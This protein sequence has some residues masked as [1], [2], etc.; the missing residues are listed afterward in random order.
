MDNTHEWC[1]PGVEAQIDNLQG[2][3]SSTF[4]WWMEKLNRNETIHT[5][6]VDELPSHAQSEKEI[7]QSQNIQS[8]LVVPV[9]QRFEADRIH[10]I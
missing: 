3:P 6:R 2:F 1:A 8:V 4:P 10:R 7:L 9:S 5:P